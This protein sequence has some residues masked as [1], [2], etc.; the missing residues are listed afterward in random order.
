MSHP[1]TVPG[2]PSDGPLP[3]PE[4]IS[5][6]IGLAASARTG[7]A[8]VRGETAWAAPEVIDGRSPGTVASD[9]YS[10]G[11]VL[12]NLLVGH[13]PF[14]A[15]DGD[16]S[17]RALSARTLHSSPPR[18]ERADVPPDLERLLAACLDKTPGQRPASPLALARALQAIGVEAGYP[19]T[20]IETDSE[21]MYVVPAAE[22]AGPGPGHAAPE[23]APAAEEPPPW[24]S[25]RV[26]WSVGTVAL[27][28]L[29]AIGVKTVADAPGAT[30]PSPSGSGTTD[31]TAPAGTVLRPIVTAKRVGDS[32]EF[33]WR[34][35]DV[36]QAGDTFQ[37]HLRGQGS[38][39]LTNG[40]SVTIRS[41]GRLCVQVRM[42][43]AGLPPSP[44]AGACG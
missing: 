4:A 11:A 25:R 30:A 7:L 38:T 24:R 39:H 5:A 28:V 18:T 1:P 21:D 29:A 8:D 42:R 33:G 6:G 43:R 10:V 22:V 9:V 20:P 31:V 36:P 23:S 40:P 41:P 3:V 16:N 35:S 27:V 26:W 19:Q 13:P 17:P 14:W 12:W 2:H 44:Y 37:W 15:P 32:V 34:A